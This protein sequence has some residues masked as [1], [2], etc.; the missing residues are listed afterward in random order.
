MKHNSSILIIED[1]LTLL[2]TLKNS[3][4]GIVD[5]IDV[6][7][8]YQIASVLIE[9]NQ[10]SIIISDR[11]LPDGDSLDLLSY[12]HECN[13]P[14]HLICISGMKTTLQ[15]KLEGYQ[16]GTIEYLCK[17]FQ[18]AEL[19]AKIKH[20]LTLSKLPKTQLLKCADVSLNP[21]NGQ[22]FI[23]NQK[24][25]ILRKKETEILACLMRYKPSVVTKD[26]LIEQVWGMSEET[27]CYATLD[28]YIRRLRIHLRQRHQL[29]KTAR[30]FGYYLSQ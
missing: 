8:S 16:A 3:L 2:K 27:P 7:E 14:T 20:L 29:I 4:E 1:D 28:V 13:Q 21:I 10:Y 11:I 19:K 12:I 26:Q 17:P 22:L 30:G 15:E 9:Q 5:H 24:I 23:D 6:A 25:K 18:V